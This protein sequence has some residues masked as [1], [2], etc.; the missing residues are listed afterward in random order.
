MHA[1]A[2]FQ[3]DREV[4]AFLQV[5]EISEWVCLSNH[6]QQATLSHLFYPKQHS[7]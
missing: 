5:Y 3:L 6:L 7:L 4:C 1:V 2:S